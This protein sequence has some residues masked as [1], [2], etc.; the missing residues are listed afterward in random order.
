MGHLAAGQEVQPF[1]AQVAGAAHAPGAVADLAGLRLGR[2]DQ[3]A[4]ALPR[5]VRG[6]GHEEG[7]EEQRRHRVEVLQRMEVALLV[8]VG[9]GGDMFAVELQQ[10]VAVGLGAA[11]GFDGDKAAAAWAVVHGHALLPAR[12]QFF[13][14]DA[15]H[16]V[17][18]AAHGKGRDHGDGARGKAGGAAGACLCPG[19]MQRG[20]G[21]Q[22]QGGAC[23]GLAAGGRGAEA[24]GWGCFHSLSPVGSAFF[25]A[26]NAPVLLAR[27]R[28]GVGLPAKARRGS[29]EVQPASG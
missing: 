22:Q 7:R 16:G 19:A 6:H 21:G 5:R 23:K 4:H 25:T 8:E 29:G 10:R 18:A 17:R 9:Q 24:V 14:H 2:L 1:A 27:T 12:G 13:A 3:V 11:C 28:G 26:C 20:D 15:Q